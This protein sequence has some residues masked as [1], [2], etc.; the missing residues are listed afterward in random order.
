M[1]A[2]LACLM[3]SVLSTTSWGASTAGSTAAAETV[4]D[5]LWMWAHPAGFHDNYF[6]AKKF[7]PHKNEGG[8]RSRITPV[9][10][11]VRL[12][13]HNIMFVYLPQSICITS[14]SPPLPL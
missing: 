11:A 3:T 9:E 10:A 8:Y 5:R 1:V 2:K 12:D 7:G 6:H 13:L 4:G 14:S